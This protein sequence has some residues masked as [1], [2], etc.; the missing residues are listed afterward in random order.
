MSDQQE[1]VLVIR[2]CDKD[3][4]AHGGFQ[5]P[6][7]GGVAEAPDWTPSQRCGN[8]LHGLLEGSGDWGHFDWSLDAK[9]MIVETDK[10]GIIELGGKVKFRSGVV[11]KIGSLAGLLCEMVADKLRI[12]RMVQ[13]IT[14]AASGNASQLAASGDASKLAASGYGS[15]LA[16]TGNDSVVMCAGYRA[17]AKAGTNGVIA[18]AWHD[19]SRP[20]V[21][22]GYVGEGLKADTWYTVEN[23]EWKEVAE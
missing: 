19:G 7:V 6:G 3:L 5:W 13:A 21:A 2:T 11:R 16:A 12:N 20:R 14:D 9:A 17:K 23:G 10:S 4:K 1:K 22:V 15:Q 18:L 8:G